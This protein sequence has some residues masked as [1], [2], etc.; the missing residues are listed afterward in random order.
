MTTSGAPRSD[1]AETRVLLVDDDDLLRESLGQNLLDAGFDVV[2]FADGVT[3]LQRLAEGERGDLILLDWKMPGMNGIEVLRELR[4][5]SVAIPVIFLTVLSEQIYEEAAL[6]GGAVDFIEK[7]RSFAIVLKRIRLIL[8][9]LKGPVS[10]DTPAPEELAVGPLLL[11]RQS[12]RALWRG[13]QVDLTLTEFRIVCRLAERAGKDVTYR[14]IYDIVHGRGFVAGADAKGHRTNVRAFI[15][16]IRQKFRAVDPRFDLIAN[17]PGFGYR[18]AA[19]K[20]S[21]G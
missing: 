16:R 1:G 18:W 4:G 13:R 15:K 21:D 11:R 20:S 14:D 12:G 3:L 8:A 2:E 7:S 17:Y 9:G 5:R 10:D 19:P 6:I